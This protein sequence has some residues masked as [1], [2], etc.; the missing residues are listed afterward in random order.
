MSF[1]Y[2]LIPDNVYII[3][4][5]HRVLPVM[6]SRASNPS[7]RVMVVTRDMYLELIDKRDQDFGT[8]TE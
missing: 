7:Q 8:H 2:E 5:A 6:V 1:G 3:L 4:D